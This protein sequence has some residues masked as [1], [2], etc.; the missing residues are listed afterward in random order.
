MMDKMNLT[1]TSPTTD[2]NMFSSVKAGQPAVEKKTKALN[3]NEAGVDFSVQL[4]QANAGQQKIVGESL[5]TVKPDLKQSLVAEQKTGKPGNQIG[6]QEGK[7][8][9]E[10]S[11][12]IGK[13]SPQ[14]L[15]A[16]AELVAAKSDV[17]NRTSPIDP[18][19]QGLANS[20]ALQTPE[21]VKTGTPDNAAASLTTANAIAGLKSYGG[22]N[23]VFEGQ[24][25]SGNL[26]PLFPEASA[27]SLPQLQQEQSKLTQLVSELQN[28]RKQ[29]SD[30]SDAS[31]SGATPTAGGAV[32]DSNNMSN[33][34]RSDAVGASSA[35]V[36]M[37]MLE[38][39]YPDLRSDLQ[40]T[41]RLA[42]AAE[43]SNAGGAPAAA[44]K[45]G[46]N[47]LETLSTSK[48]QGSSALSAGALSGAEFLNML[49]GV[50]E[51]RGS[52]N[53]PNGQFGGDSSSNRGGQFGDQ[54]MKSGK[55]DLR[56]D[57]RLIEGGVKDKKVELNEALMGGA[58]LNSVSTHPKTAEGSS[59][60][61][62]TGRVTQGSMTQDRLTSESL[63][64]MS[65]GIRDLSA[66][67][68]GEMR[69]R[70]HPDNLGEIHLRVVTQGNHVGLEIQ[71]SSDKA[72]KI[73][74]DSMSHL[75]ESL[76]SHSLTL[77][78]VDLRVA[79]SN[80][81]FGLGQE[82]RDQGQSQHQQ[83]NS[84]FNQDMMANSNSSQGQGRGRSS[85]N[86]TGGESGSGSAR[87]SA[88]SSLTGNSQNAALGMSAAGRT[89]FAAGGGE[90]SRLD[91]MA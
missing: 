72:K 67:G 21:G 38:K 77:G 33:K 29:V 23:W 3:E 81:A 32:I 63:G 15:A 86:W 28:L 11:P 91:V 6:A 7:E 5:P 71:A 79:Q 64:N 35:P 9:A 56:P 18:K 53:S 12:L 22:A 89:R 82:H 76:A 43:M 44:I 83:A 84:S 70:L 25:L 39:M 17:V 58:A 69:V 51:D 42:G 49:N 16:L 14:L 66:Q 52:R 85:E 37:E 27:Q 60:L 80:G 2:R 74:E 75:K 36:T 90:S 61:E 31:V 68:G 45:N 73:L 59:T 87:I 24:D 57:L 34:M 13:A 26:K 30:G 54:N 8:E 1:K 10:A 41:M 78:A 20:S 46:A 50:Q 19:S 62:V 65:V 4:A 47:P 40:L 88:S 48:A 55:S